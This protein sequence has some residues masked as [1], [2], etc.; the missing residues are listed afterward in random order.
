[1]AMVEFDPK[2]VAET[3]AAWRYY[4]RRSRSAA[5]RFVVEFDRAI[6]RIA[7]D[8]HHWPTYFLETRVYKLTRFP[9]LVVYRHRPDRVQIVALAHAKRRPAYWKTRVR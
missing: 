6:E 4:L 9:Y 7:K 3:R 8:P 2:A 5:D 1:M